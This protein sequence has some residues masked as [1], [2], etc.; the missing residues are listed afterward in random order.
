MIEFNKRSFGRWIISFLFVFILF[1]LI[2]QPW[3]LFFLRLRLFN[4][5]LYFN[6]WYLFLYNLWLWF[7]WFILSFWFLLLLS[8]LNF[9]FLLLFLDRRRLWW[10]LHFFPLKLEVWVSFAI[11][12]QFARNLSWLFVQF[13]DLFLKILNFLCLPFLWLF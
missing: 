8:L 1:F 9:L 13:L 6:L 4:F 11:L 12:F 2:I 3:G 5:R 7:R 10:L